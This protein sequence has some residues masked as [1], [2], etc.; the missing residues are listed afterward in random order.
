MKGSPPKHFHAENRKL[1]AEYP[2]LSALGEG[3]G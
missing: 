2:P 1:S 3:L